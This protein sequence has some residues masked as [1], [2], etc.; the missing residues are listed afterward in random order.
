MKIICGAIQKKGRL[1]DFEKIKEEAKARRCKVTDL[2]ALSRDNDPFYIG[3]DTHLKDAEWFA[4]F[5]KR[6]GFDQKDEVHLR[7]IHYQLI[8]QKEPVLMAN[9]MPYVK[10]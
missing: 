10:T 4:D 5:W 2:I 3:T 8:S 9:G 7:R 1:M 6:F